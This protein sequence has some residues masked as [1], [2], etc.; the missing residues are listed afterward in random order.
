MGCG[1]TGNLWKPKSRVPF[2][3]GAEEGLAAGA[4]AAFN[5]RRRMLDLVLR[6]NPVASARL[7]CPDWQPNCGTLAGSCLYFQFA[8]SEKAP[9]FLSKP[10][11]ATSCDLCI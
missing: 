11:E 9:V 8:A 2:L 1:E 5:I 7:R 3:G 6:V 4:A 10:F